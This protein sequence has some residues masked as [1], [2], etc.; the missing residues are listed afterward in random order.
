[1]QW[2]DNDISKL[3]SYFTAGIPD[4][5]I[6]VLFGVSKD[7]IKIKRRKCGIIG[8]RSDRRISKSGRLRMSTKPTGINSHLWKGGR[9]INHNGYVEILLPGHPRARGNGYVFEH[10]VVAEQ[11]LDRP[12]LPHEV[13]HHI[14]GNKQNN[15]PENIAVY[16]R[17]D[18]TRIHTPRRN[19]ECPV[20]IK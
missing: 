2:T 3:R 17:G 19:K 8:S 14:D 15:N 20:L 13:V 18:H 9:R 6:A 7:A 12:L 16:S 1:M 10:I 11:E 5:D 4:A